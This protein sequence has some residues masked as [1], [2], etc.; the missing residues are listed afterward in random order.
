MSLPVFPDIK[1]PMTPNVEGEDPGIST[2]MES[3]L[4]VSRPRFTKSRLSFFLKWGEKNALSTE[5][6]TTLLNFYQNTAKG[7][8]QMF[9][10]TCN[11][12]FSPYY[13]QTFK[14][15]FSPDSKLKINNKTIGF[16]TASIV[17]VEA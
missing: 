14:V 17:L 4:V 13:N 7:S 6:K 2:K 3:G 12:K 11:S 10:W 15:R 9:E 8:S 5:E 1:P 16:W